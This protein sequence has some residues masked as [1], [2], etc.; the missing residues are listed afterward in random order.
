MPSPV[1]LIQQQKQTM[2]NEKLTINKFKLCQQSAT[3]IILSKTTPLS[4]KEKKWMQLLC[5]RACSVT[6]AYWYAL[7]DSVA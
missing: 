4:R 2:N 5:T 6:G 3:H 1:Q 7:V